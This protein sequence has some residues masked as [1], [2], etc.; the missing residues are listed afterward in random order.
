MA[1]HTN[2]G[3][4]FFPVDM[5][6][7]NQLT[8]YYESYVL[9]PNLGPL[10]YSKLY[11]NLKQMVI[12]FSN[13]KVLLANVGTYKIQYGELPSTPYIPEVVSIAGTP[14]YESVDKIELNIEE[15]Y[16][17]PANR[18]PEA[19]LYSLNTIGYEMVEAA[20]IA[21]TGKVNSERLKDYKNILAGISKRNAV[22]EGLV[23]A[24]MML[25]EEGIVSEKLLSLSAEKQFDAVIRG[26]SGDK[27][28]GRISP[29]VAPVGARMAKM[30]LAENTILKAHEVQMTKVISSYVK[31][32]FDKY[33][34][35]SPADHIK[36]F[37]SCEWAF[38]RKEKI[39]I[40]LMKP[41]FRGPLNLNS[42]APK[43]ELTLIDSESRMTTAGTST[44]LATRDDLKEYNSISS[45]VKNKLGVLFD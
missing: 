17:R 20:P 31:S 8:S 22:V 11:G 40:D 25:S 9:I 28:P 27:K 36:V 2:I 13:I 15:A 4:E 12:D 21:N 23:N 33:K 44:L 35:A 26:L 24:N 39:T 29:D 30:L 5:A 14:I 34:I 42:V 41:R 37:E 3:D 43:S 10:L 45:E 32:F 1:L 18:K 19:V 38:V 6:E 7:P 16:T